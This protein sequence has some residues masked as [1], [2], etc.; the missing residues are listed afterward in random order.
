MAKKLVSVDAFAQKVFDWMR[1]KDTDFGD[2]NDGMFKS[3]MYSL[4]GEKPLTKQD[5]T[6]VR[7]KLIELQA[8]HDEKEHSADVVVVMDCRTASPFNPNHV[9]AYKNTPTGKK[10]AEATFR[11]WVESVR[12]D[13][14][15]LDDDEATGDPEIDADTKF[16]MDAV[17]ADGVYEI[18]EGFIAMF[19]TNT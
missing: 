1:A 6:S 15:S 5:F 13:T 19:E 2:Y 12:D 18:G 9:K 4:N 7:A 10:L 8:A 11:E 3:L 14:E 17:V 16:D